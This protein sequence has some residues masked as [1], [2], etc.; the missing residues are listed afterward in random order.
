MNWPVAVASRA[1][2]KSPKL[3]TGMGNTLKVSY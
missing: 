2:Q 1:I 3:R